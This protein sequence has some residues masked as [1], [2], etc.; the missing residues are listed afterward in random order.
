MD[1]SPYP[2]V[3]VQLS[4]NVATVTLDRPEVH[5][6]LDIALIKSL[7]I[8][9]R[10]LSEREDIRAIVLS[11]NGPSFSAG[12]D[13]NWMRASLNWSREENIADATALADLFEVINT[14]QHAVIGRAHGAV[15]GGGIGLIA[16]CDIAIAAE[17]AR[18]AFSEAKLGLVPAVIA[19]YVIAK[20]GQSQ[21]RALFLTAERFDAARALQIGLIH[22]VVPDAELDSAVEAT[23]K[24][25]HTSGPH[26]IQLAKE[27]LFHID[28][29][30]AGD[31]TRLT[32]ETIANM[33]V[34][35]EGQEGL[36]AFLEKRRPS[37]A[38]DM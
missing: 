27:L 29:L 13:L 22:R 14:C 5:N 32:V 11:G 20:I 35:P 1:T 17:S 16:C 26:A 38:E 28:S 37:W 6:A 25:L 12:G 31:V 36:Q 33:R 3:Q 18:F 7:T 23:I 30:P 34:S 19:P 8:I 21:A 2:S 10:D 24:Q 9:F 15:M 4:G